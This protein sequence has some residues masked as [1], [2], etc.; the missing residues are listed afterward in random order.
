MPSIRMGNLLC[1]QIR[2]HTVRERERERERERKRGSEFE[3][4]II[5]FIF[6]GAQCDQMLDNFSIICH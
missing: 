3:T 1:V 4:V 6:I 2:P 5:I